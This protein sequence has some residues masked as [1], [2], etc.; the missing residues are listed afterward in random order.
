MG[1]LTLCPRGFFFCVR[2]QNSIGGGG[3]ILVSILK[4]LFSLNT[5]K[6]RCA[7]LVARAFLGEG[8]FV[9]ETVSV[10]DA[11]R[12]DSSPGVLRGTNWGFFFMRRP[13]GRAS[14]DEA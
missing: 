9:C 3:F 13:R 1:W 7:A 12:I 2:P 5:G 4:L 14:E 6:K 8:F 11:F 10:R